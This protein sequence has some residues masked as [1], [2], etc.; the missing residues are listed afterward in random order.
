LRLGKGGPYILGSNT[1]T[2]KGS[3][4]KLG[5]RFCDYQFW[6]NPNGDIVFDPELITDTAD[7]HFPV[8]SCFVL[9]RTKE[10][11]LVFVKLDKPYA[12]VP[13]PPMETDIEWP[14]GK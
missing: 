4:G 7:R 11:N 2:S 1:T 13:Y 12:I 6:M 14:Y 10:G 8:G 9:S 3:I 5:L